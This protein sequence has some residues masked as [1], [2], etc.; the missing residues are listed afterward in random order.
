[1]TIAMG[2][3]HAGY[4]MKEEIKAY[5]L[6]LGHEV[7]DFGTDTPAP[8]DYPDK[9]LAVGEAVAAGEVERGILICG[10]GLGAS[11]AANKVPGVRAG[12]C[13][14]SYSARQGV[15]H[16]DMNVLVFGS[17][18]IGIEVARELVR[19]FLCASF[20]AEERHVRRLDKVLAIEAHYSKEQS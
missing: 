10:S 6:M 11:I 1:M 13:A 17:R 18:V 4:A 14:D 7:R 12:N 2:A 8:C 16:D 15:E 19:A 3:D 20:S 5:V 9:A